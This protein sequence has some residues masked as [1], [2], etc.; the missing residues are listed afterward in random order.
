MEIVL[1]AAVLGLIPAAI[2]SRKGHHFGWWWL[3]GAALFIVALP[4]SIV[5]RTGSRSVDAQMVR[6][7]LQVVESRP[8]QTQREIATRTGLET[9]QVLL[10]LVQLK[11][12]GMIRFE[13]TGEDIGV[14]GELVP[15]VRVHPTA[16]DG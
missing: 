10:A 3:Y 14:G 8:G 6:D 12:R 2:A 11:N 1:A 16:Q 7:V 5:A 13:K 4:H 15:E 9:N